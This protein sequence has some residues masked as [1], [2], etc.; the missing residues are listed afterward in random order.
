MKPENTNPPILL[1]DKAPVRCVFQRR[2]DAPHF[3][4]D[5]EQ[6]ATRLL[7]VDEQDS[8]N[9]W[10]QDFPRRII[11]VRPG[12]LYVCDAHYKLL[13]ETTNDFTYSSRNN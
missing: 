11:T 13:S 7:E 8:L 2:T 12:R 4:E 9:D 6:D 5:C 10:M 1:Q 3:W